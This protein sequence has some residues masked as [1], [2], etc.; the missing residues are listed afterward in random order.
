MKK[1]LITLV[2]VFVSFSLAVPPALAG[3]KQRRRWEGVAIGIGAAILGHALINKGRHHRD[4]RRVDRGACYAPPPR[5]H[6]PAPVYNSSPPQCRRGHW[7][8]RKA[9]VPPTYKKVWNPGHYNHRREWVPGQ[10]IKIIDQEGHWVEDR[11]WV[12]R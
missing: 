2:V 1:I 5:R 8:A 9:W 10:W 7:E 12:R 3:S 6:R 11:V 4:E